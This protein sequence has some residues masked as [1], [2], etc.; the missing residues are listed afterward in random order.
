MTPKQMLKIKFKSGDLGK[1]VTVKVWLQALLMTLIREGEGFSG[2]RPFGESS[3]TCDVAVALI[4]AGALKGKLDD[5]GFPNDF[6]FTDLDDLLIEC[7][8]AL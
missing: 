1:T 4:K 7:I 5:D 6:E 8:K 3:W 2:K